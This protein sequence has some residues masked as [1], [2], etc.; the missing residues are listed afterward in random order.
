M[1]GIHT[2]E[3][4]MFQTILLAID[5]SENA[6]RAAE[7]ACGLVRV[8]NGASLVVVYVAP[9]P[10]SQ[11]RIMKADFDV[12]TLLIEDAQAVAGQTLEYIGNAGVP[13]TLEAGMGDPATEI[14]KAGEKIKAGLIVIGSR[15]LGSLKGVVQGSVSQKVAQLA[16][17]PVMIVK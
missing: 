13:Y 14:L 15:G 17:C 16:T 3:V 5:G 9:N 8:I 7:A 1:A 10:P 4:L 2:M 11:S 12:H 6:R